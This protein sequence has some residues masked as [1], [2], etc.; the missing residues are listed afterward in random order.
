[1]KTAIIQGGKV[2]LKD[3]A[4]LVAPSIYHY[5]KV[6]LAKQLAKLDKKV[7]NEYDEFLNTAIDTASDPR[8]IKFDE[9]VGDVELELPSRVLLNDGTV[10][11]Q[12][13][14][15]HCVA[16]W[17]TNGVN[18]GRNF[19]GFSS[20]KKPDTLVNYIKSKLDPKISERGTYIVNGPKGAKALGWIE[21]YTQTD[22]LEEIKKSIFCG[23]PIATGTN[24][25]SWTKTKKAWNVAVL[26]AGGGH[27]ISVVWYDDNLTRADVNGKAYTWF[28]IVEN[29]WGSSWGD[30]WL[31][32]IPYE[33][34][35]KV[36]FNT[37]KNLIVNKNKSRKFLETIL[38]NLRKE[39]EKR[40]VKPAEV[41]K[42]AYF[43]D[44]AYSLNTENSKN[45]FSVLQNV[46][47]ETGYEPILRTI[48]GASEEETIN[49]I[50]LE[51]YGARTYER[52]KVAKTKK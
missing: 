36:L 43:N 24:K 3:L 50:L 21:W 4:K 51:I 12:G 15:K 46:L 29:T 20:D 37:K 7:I 11:N 30:S 40:N 27:F 6:W 5:L 10:L 31:Y 38:D 49:R 47:K 1:M 18:E 41:Q 42:Y 34:W 17:T 23:L 8:D 33:I 22:T 2:I 16:F 14:T 25:L 26:W 52:T 28:L 19:L 39:Q 9:V 48:I 35:D 45:L 13:A 32:Y 44:D